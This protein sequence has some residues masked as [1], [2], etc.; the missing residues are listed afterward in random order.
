M[1]FRSERERE[2]ERESS[3][4]Q[5]LSEGRFSILKK[6]DL[7]KGEVFALLDVAPRF[8]RDAKVVERDASIVEEEADGLA[9]AF[10]VKVG[11]TERR[12]EGIVDLSL[13]SGTRRVQMSSHELVDDERFAVLQD[14]QTDQQRDG[15][16]RDDLCH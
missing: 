9:A 3:R 14:D 8:T 11:E 6:R 13:H 2:R 5:P 16:K 1:L 7:T 4:R 15:D 12:R 10:H